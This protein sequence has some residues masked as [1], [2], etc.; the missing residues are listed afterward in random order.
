MAIS[1]KGTQGWWNRAASRKA[2]IRDERMRLGLLI[3]KGSI[4][5]PEAISQSNKKPPI[6]TK[7]AS[8]ILKPPMG[9]T[10]PAC[11]TVPRDGE[12]AREFSWLMSLDIKLRR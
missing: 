12:L 2:A 9:R 7:R 8:V 5:R 4:H 1:W 6:I 11:T 10:P 3:K